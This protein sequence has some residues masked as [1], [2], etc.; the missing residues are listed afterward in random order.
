[1]TSLQ[2][3]NLQPSAAVADDRGRA[4]ADA[5]KD[6]ES[7]RAAL[8]NFEGCGLKKTA[9]SLVFGDGNPFAEVMFIGEAPGA[10]EDRDGIPF[11]GVSGKL[12][13]RMIASIGLDRQSVYITNILPWRPPGNREPTRGEIAACLP[14]IC[15][16]IALVDP[17][18]L[19]L[20]GGTSAKT[21]LGRKEG[22]MRLR[23][24]WMPLGSGKLDRPI[25]ALAMFHPA[26]LLRSPGQKATAWKDL[27]MIKAKLRSLDIN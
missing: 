2:S 17:K 13:D 12:L 7:L 19:V 10:D 5:S 11:V 21:L 16:H 23:G 18:I 26:F 22:I 25:P 6:L 27:L 14:F 20:V 8:E 24:R 9:K 3:I 1:M 15:R 4:L